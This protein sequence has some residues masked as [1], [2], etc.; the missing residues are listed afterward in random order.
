[1]KDPENMEMKRKDLTP[2]EV[3]FLAMEKAGREYWQ[4]AVKIPKNSDLKLNSKVAMRGHQ[5]VTNYYLFSQ[6]QPES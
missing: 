3:V 2:L 1:M 5:L 4:I 6:I